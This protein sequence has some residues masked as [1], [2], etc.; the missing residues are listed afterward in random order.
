MSKTNIPYPKIGSI[1]PE[2]VKITKHCMITPD[3]PLSD[4]IKNTNGVASVSKTRRNDNVANGRRKG[5]PTT[6]SSASSTTET[7]LRHS[8]DATVT[9]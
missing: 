4:V 1:L 7:F 8:K 9:R 6:A 2:S 3:S 5:F